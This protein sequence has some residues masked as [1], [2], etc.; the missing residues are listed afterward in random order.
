MKRVHNSVIRHW[1]QK[2]WKKRC[3]NEIQVC[4]NLKLFKSKN[5]FDYK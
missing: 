4:L 2:I 1:K 3:K 5:A